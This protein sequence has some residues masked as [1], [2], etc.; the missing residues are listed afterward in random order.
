M[1]SWKKVLRTG[2]FPQ[3]TLDDLQVLRQ[4]LLEDS[5]QLLQGST[6]KPPPLQC[7]QDWPVEAACSIGYIGWKSRGLET[8][9]AVEEFFAT[10]C[11]R[12]DQ[13]M[14]EP[15]ACRWAVNWFDDNPRDVM[16]EELLT[17]INA[18]IARLEEPCLAEP[19]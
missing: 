14:N 4:A 10:T 8:V 7:V 17:E 9:G 3:L 6:T 18:Q 16:R 2:I 19:A 5:P 1:E 13:L 15:A 12:C 11:F